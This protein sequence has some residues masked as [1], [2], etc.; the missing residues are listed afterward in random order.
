MIGDG[1]R[2]TEGAIARK[3]ANFEHSHGASQPCQDMQKCPFQ[4]TDQH[5]GELHRPFRFFA[6]RSADRRFGQRMGGRIG[7][8][9]WQ[10]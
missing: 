5:T 3:H 6:E 2:K 10:N 9:F 1:F 4:R 8:N 7:V